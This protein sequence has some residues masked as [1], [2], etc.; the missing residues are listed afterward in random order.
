MRRVGTSGSLCRA[1]LNNS[2]TKSL[3]QSLGLKLLALC[4][5]DSAGSAYIALSRALFHYVTRNTF[6]STCHIR[7]APH[8][9]LTY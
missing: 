4:D 6:N 1:T 5:L 7:H 2:A 8:I 9:S 3:H